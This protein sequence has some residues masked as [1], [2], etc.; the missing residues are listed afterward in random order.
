MENAPP[1]KLVFTMPW[2]WLCFCDTKLMNFVIVVFF[3]FF[4]KY[5]CK[6]VS[7]KIHIRYQMLSAF[8]QKTFC[9]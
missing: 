3:A 4:L 2:N 6:D 1:H 5:L 9:I 8:C 7:E